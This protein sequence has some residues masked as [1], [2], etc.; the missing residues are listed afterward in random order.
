VGWIPLDTERVFSSHIPFLPALLHGLR[1]LLLELGVEVLPL[2][3]GIEL[4]GDLGLVKSG[5]P[6][7]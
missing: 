5:E 1:V 2:V 3:I 4:C 7:A 6:Y